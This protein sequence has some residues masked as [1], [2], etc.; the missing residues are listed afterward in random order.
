M[1]GLT[2]GVNDLE[3]FL[4]PNTYVVTRSTSARQI[5]DQMV[6]EFRKNFTPELR[7]KAR[8]ARV[9]APP[10]GHP[11]VDHREG[12][13]R[14]VGGPGDRR[15]V[16]EP[17]EEGDAAAGRSHGDVRLEEGRPV[18]RACSTGPTTRTTRRTT[19][20]STTVSRPGRSAIPASPRS[21]R[22]SRRRRRTTCTSS[23]TPRAGTRSRA[24]SKSTS[25]RSRPRAV[26]ARRRERR[27]PTNRS[28]RRPPRRPPRPR[29]NPSPCAPRPLAAARRGPPR[30]KAVE[31]G[32]TGVIGSRSLDHCDSGPTIYRS[33]N[34]E[35]IQTKPAA[36]RTPV[37][38]VASPPVRD[39]SPHRA[40]LGE[41]A[42]GR[43]Y[44]AIRLSGE[45]TFF[46]LR[47]PRGAG[48]LGGSRPRR[49][50]GERRDPRVS[51]EPRD[52][53]RRAARR[54]RGR[55]VPRLERGERAH[56]R[57]TSS[58]GP[59]TPRSPSRTSTRFSSPRR[60]RRRSTTP[61][62]RRSTASGLLTGSCGPDS[63]RSRTTAR[64][65]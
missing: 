42:L 51:E 37:S 8:D 40:R 3:G 47:D 44:R 1:P 5:V 15:R 24:P 12:E 25:R 57:L 18:D 17:V 50:R 11:G 58:S 27:R 26:S 53:A 23:R 33:S 10:G 34:H 65:A 28:R 20:T 43:V 45:R 55:P 35:R 64:R 48:D 31:T 46:R 14:E 38:E 21:S 19:R 39:L 9:H 22:P 49:D 54:R 7:D 59:A 63:S 32:E 36:E 61:T 4:F 2:N 60:S 29:N 62:T 41:D 6:G 52:H 56:A 16:P 30:P 13:R